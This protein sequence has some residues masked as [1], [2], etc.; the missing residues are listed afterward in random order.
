MSFSLM[1]KNILVTRGAEQANLFA[2]KIT[3]PGGNPVVV[4]LLEIVCKETE[5]TWEVLRN[6]SQYDW[7]LFTSANGVDCFFELRKKLE[8]SSSISAKIATV[9]EKTSSALKQ[10]GYEETFTPE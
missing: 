9:G 1:Q 8:S 3:Q 7:I 2:D 4:P 5:V 10:Y 6:L